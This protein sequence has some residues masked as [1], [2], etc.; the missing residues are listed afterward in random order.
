MCVCALSWFVVSSQCAL[1]LFIHYHCQLSLSLNHVTFTIVHSMNHHHDSWSFSFCLAFAIVIV[2][3]WSVILLRFRAELQQTHI[4]EWCR[5]KSQNLR[6]GNQDILHIFNIIL[7]LSLHNIDTRSLWVFNI[8]VSVEFH[9]YW[10]GSRIGYADAC[11][12]L[13]LKPRLDVLRSL[14]GWRSPIYFQ[15]YLWVLMG[16][17]MSTLRNKYKHTIIP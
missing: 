16:S 3:G 13:L 12:P 9:G 8:E 4:R 15:G 10:Q 14:R 5:K 1:S 6:I 11:W 7:S 2:V 17:C